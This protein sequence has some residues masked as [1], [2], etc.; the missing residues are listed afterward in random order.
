[1]TPQSTE[2]GI[3][4]LR[5]HLSSYLKLVQNGTE[6]LVTDRGRPVARIVSAEHED[7]LQELTRRGLVTPPER[8]KEK[9]SPDELVRATGSVSDLVKEQR[10]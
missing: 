3:R 10:R 6:V 8:P 2:I 1:M 7:R 4:E 9:L 5:D